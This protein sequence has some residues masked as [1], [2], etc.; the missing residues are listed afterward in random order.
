MNLNGVTKMKF[1]SIVVA[2]TV[3]TLSLALTSNIALARGGKGHHHDR[4]VK[5]KPAA[6]S[7]FS[8]VDSDGD[9]LIYQS[10]FTE[11]SV[12]R[13]AK[14]FARLDSDDSLFISEEEY[15]A[16]TNKHLDRLGID[17][18]AMDECMTE[19]LGDEYT[20]KPDWAEFSA[21]ADTDLDE[22]VSEAEY[23]TY[24]TNKAIE[25]FVE[26]DTSLD[27]AL[28]EE[29]FEVMLEA[30]KAQHDA[31]RTCVDTILEEMAIE[32]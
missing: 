10:E 22:L 25:Q 11:A 24:V 29:E 2:A 23:T 1:N 30:K 17:E 7:F 19:Q 6:E 14:H 32:E 15:D 12:E 28:D 27:S 5:N 18:E 4:G 8:R 13:A 3:S 26:L 21:A 31:R 20:A 16:Q 9:G